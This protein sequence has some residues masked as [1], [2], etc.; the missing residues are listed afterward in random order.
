MP[1]VA[2]VQTQKP[3][4]TPRWLWVGLLCLP[5]PLLVLLIPFV[6]PVRVKLGDHSLEATA[7]R[8]P[9]PVY[10]KDGFIRPSFDDASKLFTVDQGSSYLRIRL[11]EW[12][13][14]VDTQ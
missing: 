6:H 3:G 13:Y 10:V 7:F 8:Y 12:H 4:R 2:E 5:L 1:V 9:S 11:G 14:Q